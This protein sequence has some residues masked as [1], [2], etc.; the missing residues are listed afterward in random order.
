MVIAAPILME[1][2]PPASIQRPLSAA[3]AS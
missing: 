2:P 1:S 3:G